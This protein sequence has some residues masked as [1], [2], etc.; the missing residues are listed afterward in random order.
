MPTETPFRNLHEVFANFASP[1]VTPV[2]MVTE[3]AAGPSILDSLKLAF[4]DS[5]TSDVRFVV[6]G[7]D[8]HV[9]R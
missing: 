3:V 9:H 1:S 2:P 7:R 5:A 6:D 8:I 4:D